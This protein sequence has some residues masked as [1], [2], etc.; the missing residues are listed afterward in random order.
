VRGT[1]GGGGTAL[2]QITARASEQKDLTRT[3]RKAGEEEEPDTSAK[4]TM[5]QSCK[6]PV[7][8]HLSSNTC[9]MAACVCPLG[10]S[11]D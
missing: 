10:R 7:C 5:L 4:P 11:R 6:G 1:V 8:A 3:P 9:T 2:M